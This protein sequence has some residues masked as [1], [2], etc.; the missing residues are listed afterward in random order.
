MNAAVLEKLPSED[1]EK[2]PKKSK[3]PEGRNQKKMECSIELT[4]EEKLEEHYSPKLLDTIRRIFCTCGETSYRKYRDVM[5]LD[6]DRKPPVVCAFCATQKSD[7]SL[8]N[9]MDDEG[10]FRN[11]NIHDSNKLTLSIGNF[12]PAIPN[13]YGGYY[14]SYTAPP[15]KM[16]AWES[17][18][19][20]RMFQL[21]FKDWTEGVPWTPIV[22]NC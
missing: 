10:H 7:V 12:V 22:S 1:E 9:L 14:I 8:V 2:D 3:K 4:E 15:E 19:V 21:L 20:I 5:I 16:R 17:K 6:R 11:P 13:G 18:R